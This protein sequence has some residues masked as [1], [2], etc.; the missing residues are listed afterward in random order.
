MGQFLSYQLILGQ[1]KVLQNGSQA[2]FDRVCQN[3]TRSDYFCWSAAA[4]AELTLAGAELS[5]PPRLEY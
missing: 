5:A 2:K 3:H 4:A 1:C